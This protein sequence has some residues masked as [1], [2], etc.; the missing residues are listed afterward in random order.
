[1][2][3]WKLL[4][5]TLPVVLVI[6]LL[7]L[8]I[9]RVTGHPG[10]V[11]FGD[12]SAVLTA[13]A[14]LIG[15]MLTG[16]LADYKE[17]EKLPSEL[18][19]TLET[20]EDLIAVSACKPGFDAAAARRDLAGV[21]ER[22]LQWLGKRAPL[23]SVHLAIEAMNGHFQSMDLAGATAHANRSIVF[24][25]AVRRIVGRMDVVRRTSFI[26][27][28][29]AILEVIVVSILLL[30]L[31]S[32]F[33]TVVAEYTLVVSISLIYVYMLRLIRDIDDPFDYAVG[34]HAQGA[35]EIDLFPIAEYV[36][37][38]NAHPPAA[39]TGSAAGL[40]RAAPA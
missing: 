8:A 35:A 4:L 34:T 3:K 24:M 28:G 9:E 39:P 25:N 15:F 14:F 37:R 23:E 40:G 27:T 30:L 32:R 7:K 13:G 1:M 5:T 19:T 20:I 21:A 22:V 38:A 16:T 26:Q 17:C 29:Y 31:A 33:K 12:V 10:W 18:V 36:A 6:L 2:L 11:D